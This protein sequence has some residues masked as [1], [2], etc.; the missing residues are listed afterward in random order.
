MGGFFLGD[1]ESLTETQANRSLHI[2]MKLAFLN[3][4]SGGIQL[5]S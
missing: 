3:K 2:G 4:V 5:G 1:A